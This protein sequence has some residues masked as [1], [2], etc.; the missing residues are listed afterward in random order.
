MKNVKQYRKLYLAETFLSC[1]FGDNCAIL[2]DETPF[3]LR[4]IL[5]LDD[6]VLLY[7]E[8]FQNCKDFYSTPLPSGTLNIYQVPQNPS[9][10]FMVVNVRDV[11]QKCICLPHRSN[12]FVIFPLVHFN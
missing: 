12:S 11:V 5:T 3:F 4:N 9:G 8:I 7:I 2:N 1:D 10:K 6:N